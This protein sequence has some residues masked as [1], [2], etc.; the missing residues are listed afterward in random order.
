[1]WL[2]FVAIGTVKA[3]KNKGVTRTQLSGS[4]TLIIM[5]VFFWENR[6]VLV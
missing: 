4:V 1:M 2:S 6:Y 5:R 3:R